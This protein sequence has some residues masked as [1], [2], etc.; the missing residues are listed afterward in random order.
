MKNPEPIRLLLVDDHTIV[1]MGLRGI[2]AAEPDLRVVA[3]AENGPQALEQ[4]RQ[5]RPDVT[6]MDLRMPGWDGVE[7][8]LRIRREFRE[9]RILM[10]STYDGDH[11]IRRALQAGANGYVLKN[12]SGEE[13]VRAIKAVQEGQRYLPGAVAASLAAGLAHPALTPRELEVL[14]LVAKGLA[15]KEIADVLSMTEHTAKA[16]LKSILAKLGVRDRTEA[17]TTAL[18][19]G[20]VRLD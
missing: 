11:D 1:R 14:Q 12:T 9:A 6:L 18:R 19:R 2:I 7:T 10:L 4:Y 16:H 15:N 5:H 17:A 13:L 3:E 20:L 8:T